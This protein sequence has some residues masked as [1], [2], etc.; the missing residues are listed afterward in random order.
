MRKPTKE[1]EDYIRENLRY[2]PETGHL[3]WTKPSESKQGRRRLD[4]PTGTVHKRHGYVVFNIG[5]S[6]GRVLCRAH[7]IAWFLH[8]GSWPKDM[9]DH[10]NG[11]RNDNKIENLRAAT[12]KENDRNRK[13]YKECSSKYK[14]V[15][16]DKRCQKWRSYIKFN[17]RQKHLGI[18][19]SEEE[20]ARAYDKAARECFGDYA[21]LNFPDQHEQGALHG[22][23]L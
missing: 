1:D 18:Y 20:A 16:W 22:H 9:L 3:W 11:I 13:S 2:D 12:P 17:L 23:D 6:E 8:Y 4:K 15:S 14:G 7:R 10:I 19:T 21:C 5:L